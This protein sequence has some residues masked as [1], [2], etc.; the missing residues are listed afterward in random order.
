MGDATYR[1]VVKEHARI[2][3]QIYKAKL[4][5][6][7]KLAGFRIFPDGDNSASTAEDVKRYL[8]AI[9][10]VGG[11]VSFTSAKMVLSNAVHKLGLPPVHL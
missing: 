1:D 11:T 3:A 4:V 2:A 9:Q 8:A 7:E 10:A 6:I 5:E